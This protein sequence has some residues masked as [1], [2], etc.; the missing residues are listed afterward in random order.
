MADSPKPSSHLL[1]RVLFCI[2]AGRLKI[3]HASASVATQK[4]K[5]RLISKTGLINPGDDLLSPVRT[6][7]GRTG[8]ASEF[9]MGSGVSPHVWSPGNS[10]YQAKPNK[11]K[12]I[13]IRLST[14]SGLSFVAYEL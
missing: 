13:R 2:N 1:S 11:F 4:G 8:L 7:I 3:K 5:P 14:N 12:N 6:T 9:G 10:F